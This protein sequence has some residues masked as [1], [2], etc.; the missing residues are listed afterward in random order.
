MNNLSFCLKSESFTENFLGIDPSSKQEGNNVNSDLK[1][2]RNKFNTMLDS[3]KKSVI[4]QESLLSKFNNNP[5]DDSPTERKDTKQSIFDISTTSSMLREEQPLK[6][7]MQTL[8][9]SYQP[10]IVEESIVTENICDRGY[11]PNKIE[12]NKLRNSI[13]DIND[14]FRFCDNQLQNNV[15]SN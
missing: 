12:D 2:L 13:L 8:S 9:N 3:V 5:D 15:E 4:K 1:N 10:Y 7:Y 14:D 11:I 6:L